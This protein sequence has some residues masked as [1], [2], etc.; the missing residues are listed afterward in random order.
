MQEAAMLALI[1]L[2][3]VSL[4]PT[5][6]Q[7]MPSAAQPIVVEGRDTRQ[8]A[9][10]YV[11]KLLPPTMGLE[12][13]RFEQPVCPKVLGLSEPYEKQVIDRIRQVAKATGIDVAKDGCTPNLVI[14]TAP[15]K[16]A[17]M[18]TLRKSRP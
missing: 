8:L 11:D 2:V 15:D 16:R 18:A 9:S 14:M 1:G 13:G 5:P 4:V 7:P 6:A 3:G 17:M 10:D 12:L